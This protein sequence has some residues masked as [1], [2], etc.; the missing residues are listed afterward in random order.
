MLGVQAVAQRKLKGL[1]EPN[2]EREGRG[3]ML[4]GRERTIAVS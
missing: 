3:M 4:R 2:W 1:N